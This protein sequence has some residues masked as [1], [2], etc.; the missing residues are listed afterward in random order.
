MANPS[1]VGEDAQ[2]RFFNFSNGEY[3]NIFLNR[4]MLEIFINNKTKTYH[5][6]KVC[7]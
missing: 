5:Y 2:R 4:A 3:W 6:A 1:A 7:N